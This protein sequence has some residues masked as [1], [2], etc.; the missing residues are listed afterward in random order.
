M[1]ITIINGPPRAGKDTFCELVREVCGEPFY[2]N[3]STIDFVKEVAKFCGWDGEKTPRNRAFLSD[4]KDL[5]TQ[6][7]DVPTKDVTNRVKTFSHNFPDDRLDAMAYVFIHCREPWEIDK[8]KNTL[9]AKTL[10]V[11]RNDCEKNISNHADR[12]VFNYEYDF[13]IE[14]NGTL[15]ELKEKAKE[16]VD[17]LKEGR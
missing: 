6:W 11:T 8:L 14:N 16:Y 12:D 17:K 1:N 10:L 13:V 4:L 7:D 15:E 2:L 9:K 3:I 5:L